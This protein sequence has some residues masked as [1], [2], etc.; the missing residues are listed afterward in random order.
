MVLLTI[1]QVQHISVDKMQHTHEEEI[2]MLNE[3]DELAN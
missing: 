1:D 3:I 2:R